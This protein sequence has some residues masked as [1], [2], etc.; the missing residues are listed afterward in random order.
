MVTRLFSFLIALCLVL[1]TTAQTASPPPPL[2]GTHVLLK[3]D[4]SPPIPGCTTTLVIVPTAVLG[5][6]A[7]IVYTDDGT[8][9]VP[10]EGEQK[11]LVGGGGL[12]NWQNARGTLGRMTWPGGDEW[13]S[14]VLTGPNAGTVRR[15]VRQN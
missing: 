6:L 13:L 3:R 15:V 1:P 7:G 12:Y 2:I 5:V 14:E 4:G 9:P 8:G 10:L 11:V